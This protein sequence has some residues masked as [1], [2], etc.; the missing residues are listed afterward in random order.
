MYELIEPDR[1]TGPSPFDGGPSQADEGPYQA[2]TVPS[3][4]N[5]RSFQA[6]GV[7]FGP[8]EDPIRLT[9]DHQARD[10]QIDKELSQTDKGLT[11]AISS[12]I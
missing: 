7:P 2:S 11:Q 5:A 4:A 9:V 3:E 10:T 1:I 12:Q 8:K 6:D